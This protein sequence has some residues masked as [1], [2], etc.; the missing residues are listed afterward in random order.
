MLKNSFKQFLKF[1]L[2]M[3]FG[4]F[5][6]TNASATIDENG[7]IIGYRPTKGFFFQQYLKIA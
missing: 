4:F 7:A 1:I 2:V 5:F 3:F 6:A